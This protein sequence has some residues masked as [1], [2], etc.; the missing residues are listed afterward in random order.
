[1]IKSYGKSAGDK[2]ADSVTHTMSQ[3][4][5]CPCT[6]SA[7]IVT[8]ESNENTVKTTAPSFQWAQWT[9]SKGL[10][11]IAAQHKTSI[12]YSVPIDLAGKNSQLMT[13]GKEI[14]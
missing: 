9:I 12:G 1:M 5:N 4:L 7:I 2:H 6:V 13:L 11:Q 8:S 14:N 10:V 3:V